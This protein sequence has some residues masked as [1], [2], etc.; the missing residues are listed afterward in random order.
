MGTGPG[1][2]DAR[3]KDDERKGL[4][5]VEGRM[6]EITTNRRV[7]NRKPI[8]TTME[9]KGTRGTYTK[10]GVQQ[11]HTM[12]NETRIHRCICGTQYQTREH[13]IKECPE[14][15]D[16][17]PILRE[18]DEQME[19]GVL[20]GTKEGLE[21]MAKF[22]TKTGAFTKTG[23]KRAPN[24]KP[25]EEDADN[26]EDE[27]RWWRRMEGDGETPH[28]SVEEDERGDRGEGLEE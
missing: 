1:N 23:K 8:T 20:L 2:D 4:R 22:L 16:H 12:S 27:E 25:E 17:R 19:L 11:A 7:R 18:A 6:A 3:E 26:D 5:E 9:T 28:G 14:Y 21:A 15:E 13:V 10:G 24:A